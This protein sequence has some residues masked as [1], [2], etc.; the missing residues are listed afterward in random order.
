MLKFQYYNPIKF[1]YGEDAFEQI[2]KICINH[3]V[4]LVYG[5]GSIKSN[6]V[7]DKITELLNNSGIPYLDYGNQTTATY[8]GILDGIT[9]VKKEGIDAII[10]IGGASAMDTGKAIAFGAVHDNLEDYI[11]GRLESDDKHLLNIIIPTY[12]STGSEGNHV[13]DIMEYKGGGTELFGA[14]PDYCLLD[15]SVTNSLD[16]RNTAYSI[17][18]CFIQASGWYVGTHNN[19]I[20]RGFA[21]TIL[22]VLLDSYDKITENPEDEQAR[23]NIMWASCVN[24]MGIFHSGMDEFYA[25]TLYSVGYIPR[26][27]HNV[28][29]REA[30]V[31]AFP[32]WLKG[33]SKY[34]MEDIKLFFTEIFGID[35][36]LDDETIIETGCNRIK[37]MMKDSGVTDNLSKYGECP[38]KEY[39]ESALIKE[40][41]GEFTLDEL[42]AMVAECYL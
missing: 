20:S 27:L 13:C 1:I 39:V 14:W 16:Q 5:G 42:H 19:D 29:Y 24:A 36:T 4:L 6:G 34:H 26:V 35:S 18:V 11:E 40:D 33:I 31:A 22:K 3:K 21:K 30:L 41:F 8:Q 37:K 15:P 9:L 2:A 38:S 28:S 7:Y 17:L 10:E 23:G 32:N 25:W 12:P